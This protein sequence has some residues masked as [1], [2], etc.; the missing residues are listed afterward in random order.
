MYYTTYNVQQLMKRK[1]KPW[2]ARLKYKDEVTGK[3]KE[4]SKILPE[5]NGKR[6]AKKAAEQWFNEMN[7]AAANSTT[8]KRELTVGEAILRFLEYQ[9]NSG[10]IEKST[11]NVQLTIYNNYIKKDIGDISFITLD[12]NAIQVWLTK[13]NSRGLSQCTIRHALETVKK[14][15]NYYYLIGDLTKNPLLGIKLPEK[16]RAK[17][18]H[19][20]KEQMDDYL[21]AVYADY[22]PEDKFYAAALLLF[23]AGL[24]R[25]EVCGLRWRDINFE[26]NTI[27][28]V[29]AIGTASKELGGVYYT[30]QPKS[31]TSNR[32]FTMVPQLAEALR[33]RADAIEPKENWFVCGNETQFYKPNVFSEDF[34][35]F[36]KRHNLIDAYGKKISPHM[37]RHNLGA[38]GI[39]SGMDIASLSRM[40][41]HASRA[42]TLD[43][44]GDA[45]KDAMIT[46]AAKLGNTFDDETDYFKEEK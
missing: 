16:S 39:R 11:Y 4:I 2:Q 37:M 29:T 38:V 41:G 18:T 17:V 26:S 9:N 12:R 19:L 21:T 33:R 40:F 43:I 7:E 44:Y 34:R 10:V 13:L 32:T 45:T 8:I 5:V 42:M 3:W 36:V 14:V 24:R 30:K 20:T 1:N 15:Y 27:S 31:K 35:F 22:N 46:A 28:V 23:Y 6:E 25:S